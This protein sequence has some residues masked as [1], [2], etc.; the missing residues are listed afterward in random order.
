LGEGLN[1]VRS[2]IETSRE[3]SD[4]SRLRKMGVDRFHVPV[5]AVSILLILESLIGTRRKLSE[6]RAE[7]DERALIQAD[8]MR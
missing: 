8:G 6:N 3:F 4:S 1:R 2:Q 5:A 7:N